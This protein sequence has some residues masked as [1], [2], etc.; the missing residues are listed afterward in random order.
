MALLEEIEI[1]RYKND[2][3]EKAA[4]AAGFGLRLK[5]KGERD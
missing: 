1:H 4:S 5:R 3:R 2:Q